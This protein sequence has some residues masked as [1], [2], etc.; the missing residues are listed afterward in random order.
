MKMRCRHG[1]IYAGKYSDGY[2]LAFYKT[3]SGKNLIIFHV[4]GCDMIIKHRV[5]CRHTRGGSKMQRV[6][7]QEHRNID[8]QRPPF[9]VM[10][11]IFEL[12]KDEALLHLV[13]GSI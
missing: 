4:D 1:N 2:Y 8:L 10:A 6:V 12:T 5:R 9:Y 13:G 3:S 11:S 7:H